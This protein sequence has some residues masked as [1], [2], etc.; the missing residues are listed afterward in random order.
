MKHATE[1]LIERL[2][3][4]RID[5]GLT[6][7]ELGKRIGSPQ[8]YVARLEAGRTDPK[9]SSLVEVS[10]ALGLELK[11]LP[12]GAVP[13]V[14]GALR[15]IHFSHDVDDVSNRALH[16]IRNN[17]EGLRRHDMFHGPAIEELINTLSEFTHFRFNSLAIRE[18]QAALRPI[19]RVLERVE[20]GETNLEWERRFREARLRLRDLRNQLA[21]GRLADQDRQKPAF[22]LDDE[23]E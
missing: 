10:R 23:D 17:I 13:V 11:F 7:R 6:Q 14:E 16:L 18:L 22:S 5:Q 9:L 21:H 19:E 4:A 20:A 8:S 3:S 2:K 15:A 1:A 12:R